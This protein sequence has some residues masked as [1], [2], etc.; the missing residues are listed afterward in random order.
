MAAPGIPLFATFTAIE[1]PPTASGVRLPTNSCAPV[2]NALSETKNSSAKTLMLSAL[3][4]AK[5]PE[6]G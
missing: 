6:A 2:S 1:T 4:P 5:Y 3:Q